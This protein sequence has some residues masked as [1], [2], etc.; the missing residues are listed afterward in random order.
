MAVPSKTYPVIE[1]M[2]TVMAVAT[3]PAVAP[4]RMRCASIETVCATAKCLS[5]AM[6]LVD[7][8]LRTDCAPGMTV[9]EVGSKSPDRVGFCVVN[10]EKH[11]EPGQI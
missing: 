5:Q 3:N 9:R 10:I 2:T 8:L 6:G 7:G 4:A 11:A 1:V